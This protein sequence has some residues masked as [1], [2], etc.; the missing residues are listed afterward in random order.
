VED[1]QHKKETETDFFLSHHILGKAIPHALKAVITRCLAVWRN[2]Q[3]N[4]CGRYS[5]AGFHQIISF[6]F[7]LLFYDSQTHVRFSLHFPSQ[8][9]AYSARHIKSNIDN[10]EIFNY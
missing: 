9:L 2:Q 7:S 3:V 8:P 4:N 10:Y 1:T 6:F 5:L